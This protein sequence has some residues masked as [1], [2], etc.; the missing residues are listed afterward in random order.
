MM[1]L[2]A[3]LKPTGLVKSLMERLYTAQEATMA[4]GCLAERSR[5]GSLVHVPATL[6][7]LK[8]PLIR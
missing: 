3:D 4:A 7:P 8:L 5:W 6:H 2:V 1:P